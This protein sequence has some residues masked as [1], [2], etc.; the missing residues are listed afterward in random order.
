VPNSDKLVEKNAEHGTVIDSGNVTSQ[1][2]S[3]SHNAGASSQ[4]Q[5]LNLAK[6]FALDGGLRAPEKQMP[7]EDRT[8]KRERLLHL[9]KQQNIEAIIGKSLRYCS[10]SEVA[11]KADP[12][13]F[14]SF[15]ELA[16]LVSNATMQ[17]LWSKILAGEINHPGAYSLKALQ[18]FKNLSI[19][20]AKLLAKACSVAMK[21]QGKKNIRIITGCYQ[22][23]GLFNLLNKNRESQI[24]LSSFGLG[25]GE[26][27]S[28]ADNGLLSHS[29]TELHLMNKGETL[30][31]KYNGKPLV[32]TAIK[33]DVTIRLLKF[34]PAGAELAQ[35]IADKPDQQFLQSLEQGLQ[36]QFALSD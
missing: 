5:L 4:M 29:E 17:E 27:M 21:F 1:K 3:S 24:S 8:I 30:A 6:Q 25:Y 22:K 14:S 23:P 11:D 2:S 7:I 18:T 20:D 26:L 19:Y 16:E 34:T 28:L 35:L 9:R 36:H 33:N 12:D 15:V 10:D 31:M 32:L 13:W